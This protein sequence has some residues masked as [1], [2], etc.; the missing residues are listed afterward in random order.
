MTPAALLM[1]RFILHSLWVVLPF[2]ALLA[3]TWNAW[4]S[5]SETRRNRIMESAG[6]MAAEALDDIHAKL[7]PWSPVPASDRT[8]TP[9]LPVD[10]PKAMDALKRYE[11]GDFEGV[12]GSPESL[13]SH[14]G[15]PLRSLAA[16]QLLRRET[17]PARLAELASVLTEPMDFMT[18]LFLE[19][20]DKRFAELNIA[21]PSALADWRGRWQLAIAESSLLQDL[22]ET[23]W[24][25]KDGVDFLIE[26]NPQS[27]EWRVSK[28]DDVRA[29]AEVALKIPTLNLADGLAIHLSIAGK[30]VAGRPGLPS[31]STKERNGWKAEVVLTDADAYQRGE[32]RT[33]NIITAVI[34]VAGIAALFGLFQS[35]RAYL[36][37]VELARRQSEFMAAVSHEM[38]TPLAAMGLLAENLESGAAERAG[39]R[40]EHVRMIREESARLGGLID[41]VLAFTRDK[42]MGPYEAFDVSAMIADAASLM[43]PLAERKRL[44]FDLE[45]ADFS[46]PPCGDAAA[47]RRALL[48][49]LDNAIKHTP[50]GG[51]LKCAVRPIDDDHWSIEVTDSGPGVPVHERSRIFEVFYRIGDELRRTTP[52]TGLGLALV[53]RSAEAHGG[54]ITVTDA[55]GGGARFTLTLPIRL[56]R[57]INRR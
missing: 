16:L 38:R 36:H 40:D 11:A 53:K 41:N 45:V 19:E 32:T 54:E 21:P 12:L 9:P 4:R 49:L 10:D 28:E 50:A 22:E 3:L 35:G 2:C 46:E 37:A 33:R 34:S 8:G 24:K 44:A 48:N 1:K 23:T 29:A 14:A 5:D 30:S 17:D 20:A 43:K 6:R 27:R 47:L 55:P 39:K 26:I 42:P 31:F 52:G 13:R 51:T 25:N 57:V 56:E 18:P 7:G 15:L